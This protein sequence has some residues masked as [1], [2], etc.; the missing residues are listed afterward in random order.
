MDLQDGYIIH[1]RNY[2]DSSI[3]LDIFIKEFGILSMVAK[4]ARRKTYRNKGAVQLFT[5]ILV[6]WYGKSDLLT[7][8][9]IE[10]HACEY[11]LPPQNLSFGFYLNELL[12]RLLRHGDPHPELFVYYHYALEQLV[13]NKNIEVILRVFEKKLLQETGY[14]LF[15]NTIVAENNYIFKADSGFI[16]VDMLQAKAAGLATYKGKSLLALQQETLDVDDSDTLKDIKKLMRT[17][18]K[19]QLGDRPLRS[20]DLVA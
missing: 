6:S 3:I 4:G 14:E 17:V 1:R 8:K 15:G 10:I 5:P 2:L 13:A 11:M 9:N 12:V 7:L 20:R 19:I 16:V 18:I